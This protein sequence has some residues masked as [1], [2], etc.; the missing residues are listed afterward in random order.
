ML[1]A[2]VVWVPAV[3]VNDRL[4]PVNSLLRFLQG[5]LE[6]LGALIGCTGLIIALAVPRVLLCACTTQTEGQTEHSSAHWPVPIQAAAMQ[7]SSSSTVIDRHKGAA[8]GGSVTS[9]AYHSVH[10]EY[11][12]QL[13]AGAC[14]D[15]TLPAWAGLVCSPSASTQA[16]RTHRSQ[17]CP[18][19]EAS[20]PEV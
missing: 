5:C 10:A 3:S 1:Q 13:C 11:P 19:R 20:G 8:T 9:R 7:S 2:A 18:D 16:C 14:Q 17:G 12:E 15:F 6:L 4:Q